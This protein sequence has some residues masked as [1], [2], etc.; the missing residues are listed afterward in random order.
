MN[1]RIF[2]KQTAIAAPAEELFAWHAR[3]GAFERLAPPWE[4]VEIVS[5]TGSI[6]DGDTLVMRVGPGPVRPQ[7][8][9]VHSGYIEGRQFIDTQASG[10]MAHWVH[11]H[12]F[13]PDGPDA[14]I[15]F[16]RIEYALPLGGAGN[17]LGGGLIEDKLRRMFAYRHAVTREDIARG[18]AYGGPPLRILITGSSGM[19]G[20]ALAAYLSTGGHTVVRAVRAQRADSD[21]EAVS[22]TPQ[23]GALSGDALD[24]I[25]AVVHLA[26]EPIATG[27][28]T[29]NRKERIRSS[30]ALVTHNLCK[31]LARLRVKPKA[32]VSASAIGYYGHEGG[33]FT[34][35]AP[36][37]RGF[38]ADV[39]RGWEEALAPAREAGIRVV[40]LR[41]GMVISPTGGA[42]PK[43]LPA[44]RMG[45]GGPVGDG[46]QTV[47]WIG[48]DDV[49]DMTL[50]AIRTETVCGPVNAVAPNA[51]S[52]AEFAEILGRVLGR[53]AVL[54]M[55]AAGARLLFGEKADELLL[56]G[57][58]VVPE[59]AVQTGYAFRHETLEAC[60]RHCLGRS[61]T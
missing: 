36:A 3:P 30:R 22:W 13:V 12:R 47:S 45:L 46:R 56:T 31:A 23:S 18:R 1:V 55:P 60:L 43:I 54:S 28:W 7:W 25:D 40:P 15:L 14:S 34:E 49:L 5:R 27:R 50:H 21:Y 39:C 9:A 61:E 33:P 20:S 44:F 24:G 52:N 48:L 26:S 19:I 58:A 35:T 42:L 10:P 16:D 59:R 32:I 2:E 38:L 11:T 29:E 37:G 8:T 57:A 6:R 41:L 53:P 17:F 4:P 51:V